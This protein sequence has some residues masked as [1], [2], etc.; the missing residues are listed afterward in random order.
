[1]E[2]RT[3]LA[4]GL[5]VYGAIS[6]VA[7]TM[8]GTAIFVVPSIMLQH[9]G[10]PLMVIVVW[11]FAGVL[12]LFGAM[13]Y[14]ELGAAIPA[15]GGE[16][17]YLHRAYGPMLGFLYGWTYFIVAKTAS[18]AAIGTGFVI[19][20]TYFFPTLNNVVLTQEL[21]LAG[22]DRLVRLTG[23]QIGGTV[24]ILLLSGINVLGVRRSGLVQTVFTASKLLVL[25]VLIVLGLT[26]GHGSFEHF[27]PLLMKT[28]HHGFLAAFGV[29]TVSALWAYD[30]WNNLSMVASEVKNPE[31]NM[32]TALILG[33]LLVLAVY[34]LVNIAYFYVLEPRAVLATN[35]VAAAAARRF[36]GGAG[37]A[38]VAIGVLISTFATLNGSIL[39]G[40]RVPYAQA[41]DGLFPK[42]LASVNP[43]FQTP[44]IAIVAQAAIAGIFALSGTYE[45]L[46]TKVLFSEWLFYGLVTTSI[47]VLRR[48]EPGLPRPYR[49]WGYPVVPAIFA[50]LA[51]LFLVNT[52]LERRTDS[53]W[54]LALMGSGVPAYGLWRWWQRRSS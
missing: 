44:A 52:F 30:G 49:T 45:A 46:Y 4:R 29:A 16:Y 21:H 20:L 54:G 37:G 14:A 38:F 36:L 23:L 17:A 13:G 33:S 22:S 39:S 27:R 41:R 7:G 28:T 19:Y 8:I 18:I 12:S 35:T 47:F 24:M 1:M 9:V 3:E 26:L 32:V 5:G 34:V 51:A 25:A 48:R 2:E 15:A 31:R 53:L 43:R 50:L 10:T 42:A 6:V 11:A 40:S